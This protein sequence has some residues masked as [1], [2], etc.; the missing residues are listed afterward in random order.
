MRLMRFF[1]RK[2]KTPAAVPKPI[3]FPLSQVESI[4]C[5]QNIKADQKVG[6]CAVRFKDG[7]VFQLDADVAYFAEPQGIYRVTAKIKLATSTKLGRP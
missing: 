1:N 5:G 7:S 6:Y 3:K 2:K 4:V